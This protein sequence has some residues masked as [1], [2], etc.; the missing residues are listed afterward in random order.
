M[1]SLLYAG[2]SQSAYREKSLSGAGLNVASQDTSSLQSGLGLKVAVPFRL[3]SSFVPE[4]DLRAV[5]LHEFLDTAESM[6]ASFA[7]GGVPFHAV[8][9]QPTTNLANLGA[10][11]KFTLPNGYQGETVKFEVSYNA[12]IGSSFNE[13]VSMLRARYDF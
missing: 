12:L 13:Q 8:G 2:V 10:A 5:W 7:Y 4:L 11:L 1:A 9:P 3:G 6:T